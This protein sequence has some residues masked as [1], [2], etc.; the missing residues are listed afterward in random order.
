MRHRRRHYAGSVPLGHP[1]WVELLFASCISFE[2][3]C[4]LLCERRKAV[5]FHAV[6]FGPAG[7]SMYL[8]RMA[9]IARAA[10]NNAPRDPLTPAAA[11]ILS[12]YTEAL[13]TVRVHVSQYPAWILIDFWFV[14]R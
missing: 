2:L 7:H 5:S 12:S 13:D 10:Q 6:S 11:T 1:A 8:R 9:D 3:T 4:V 14:P